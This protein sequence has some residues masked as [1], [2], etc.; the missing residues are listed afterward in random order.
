MIFCLTKY[1]IEVHHKYMAIKLQNKVPI[2]G[3]NG[4]ARS[5]VGETFR[6]MEI[7]QCFDVPADQIQRPNL[8]QLAA[9]A[10]VKITVR[11]LLHEKT[12]EKIYRVWRIE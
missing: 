9:Y 1:N 10:G 11:T 8:Y 3:K 2:P 12:A 5:E 6:Q 4:R 7:G